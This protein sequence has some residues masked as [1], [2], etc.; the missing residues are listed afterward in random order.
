MIEVLPI[1]ALQ[2][3]YIWCLINR[4]NRHCVIVD[5]GEAAPVFT[6]L[7]A[8][9]LKLSA[10]LI[11][12][13]HWDH[14]NGIAEL[15]AQFDVPVYGPALEPVVGL[16]HPVQGSA[17]IVLEDMHLHWQVMDI[18]G[19]TLGHI[20][21]YTPGLVFTGDT[22]FTAGCGRLFEGTAEQMYASLLSLKSLDDNTLVYCG[23]EYTAANLKFAQCV[24]PDNLDIQ[25]RIEQVTRLREANSPTVPALLA[26]E[27]LTN[28][29]LRCDQPVVI[30]A[31]EHYAGKKLNTPQA[32]F[33]IIRNWK[34]KF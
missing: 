9:Q 14:V 11:T 27:K 10:I 23:H 20:A 13:H 5:P 4:A 26:T 29:F 16:T 8:N 34:N 2:D 28:P 18:P 21:Y 12:H 19:H 15:L 7:R 31:A 22:L 30:N 25:Q 32:V 1:K 17:E 24:E 6:M 3:N 33:E